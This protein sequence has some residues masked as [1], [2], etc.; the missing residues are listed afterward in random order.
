[1]NIESDT[2]A[3]TT[4]RQSYHTPPT[5]DNYTLS[6]HDALPIF[7]WIL[8]K[9]EDIDKYEGDIEDTHGF[10][11]NLLVLSHIKVACMFRD[12]G[13]FVK[14]SLRSS[15]EYDVGTIALALGGGGHSH[16]AATILEKKE[17]ETTEAVI[18]RAIKKVEEVLAKLKS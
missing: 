5:A 17:G 2:V 1:C 8:L 18:D 9:K 10:I 13:K 4:V 12:D 6:L 11:N 7:A 15:G 14:M 16:S 3:C